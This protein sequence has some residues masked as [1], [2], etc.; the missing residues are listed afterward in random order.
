M[1]FI[2][3]HIRQLKWSQMNNIIL[4]SNLMRRWCSGIPR[5][6]IKRLGEKGLGDVV[7]VQG[8]VRTNRKQKTLS[9]LQLNDGKNRVLRLL[10]L[11]VVER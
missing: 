7:R 11:L 1:S 6:K 3:C 10:L 8:W 5:V 2:L 9:F 4:S